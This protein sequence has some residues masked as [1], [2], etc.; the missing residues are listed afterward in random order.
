MNREAWLCGFLR[1]ECEDDKNHRT[2]SKLALKVILR[3]QKRPDYA[4]KS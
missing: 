3:L 1:W 2:P 4:G